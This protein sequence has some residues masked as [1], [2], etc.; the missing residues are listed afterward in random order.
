MAG[1]IVLYMAPGSCSRVTM[2]ALE[3]IGLVYEDRAVNLAGGGQ[4]APA[5]LAL[6][7]KG[8]VPVLVVDGRPM[9]E[10]AAIL[11]FLDRTH[12]QGL[13]LPRSEDPVSE[14]QGLSDLVWCASTLHLESRQIRAPHRLTAG[15]VEGVRTDG[16]KKLA[17][18][19][20]YISGRVAGD[21]WWYGA[22]WSIIDTYVYWAYSNAAKGGFPLDGYDTL[23]AHGERVRARPSFQKM[24]AR[25]RAAVEREGLPVDP[26]S[27]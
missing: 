24:L 9:T 4:E 3:E 20:D 17:K 7:R 10:N 13:L 6:N 22:R 12:P 26:A 2:T 18:N 16:L 11:S 23:R 1:G 15:E 14:N 19:C 27:L 5:Y 25:E 8:K 21:Q